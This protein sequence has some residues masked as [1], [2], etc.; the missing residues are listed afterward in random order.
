VK[1]HRA[2]SGRLAS[3]FADGESDWVYIDGL[4]TFEGVSADLES[5]APIIKPDGLILGHD[6]SAHEAARQMYFG[7]VEAVVGFFRRSGFRFIALTNARAQP[8]ESMKISVQ[9]A[10]SVLGAGIRKH[11]GKLVGCRFPVPERSGPICGNISHGQE[12]QLGDD[13]ISG[14]GAA[15]FEDLP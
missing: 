9:M 8:M 2:Y 12:E 11:Q 3:H 1:V 13:V 6:Y 10:G 7:V 4:H 14:E 5:Y 15:A